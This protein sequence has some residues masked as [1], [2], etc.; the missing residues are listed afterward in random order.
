MDKK[1]WIAGEEI[2]SD[3]FNRTDAGLKVLAQTSEDMTL[4][5]MEGMVNISGTIVK[6]AGGNTGTFTAPTTNP[7]IDLVS[8]DRSGTI[9]LTTGTEA[10][11]PTA[12]TYPTDEFVL[13]EVYLRT[14]STGI[15]N[16]DQTTDAYIYLDSRPW[17]LPQVSGEFQIEAGQAL[18][19]GDAVFVEDAT[20]FGLEIFA[21]YGGTF[22]QTVAMGVVTTNVQNKEVYAQSF[23]ESTAMTFDIVEVR[24]RKVGSPTDNFEIAI[25]GDS[26]GAPDGVDQ[27]SGSVAGSSLPTSNGYFSV[28]LS[29]PFT[30]SASTTYWIVYRRS[31]SLSD[32]N[33][34]DLR[35]RFSVNEYAN[36]APAGFNGGTWKTNPNTDPFIRDIYFKLEANSEEGKVY[37]TKADVS[38]RYEHFVG[39]VKE[40]VAQGSNAIIVSSGQTPAIFSSLT[41]GDQYYLSDTE[42]AIATTAGTNTRKV[43]IS[44]AADKLVVTNIW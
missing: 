26:S 35:G 31:G 21:P 2:T 10:A 44:T 11:S 18:S 8:I 42:G 22:D 6:Y 3:G 27:A 29:S 1:Y 4:R 30:A 36:G 14:S 24:G 33:Y 25:Q 38:G 19:A 5:V 15:Y 17:S 43:G 16:I 32:S 41:I 9:N 34:Y 20:G 37:K 40:T 13:C 23:N 12:P 7:R 39:F 28:T